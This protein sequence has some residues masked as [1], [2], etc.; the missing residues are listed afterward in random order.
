LCVCHFQELMDEPQVKISKHLNY[1]KRHG[2]VNARREANWMIYSLPANPSRELQAH[3]ACLQD[4]Q[5]EE[6]V[7]RKDAA[8]LA[9]LRGRFVSSSPICC[10]PKAQRSKL[11]TENV[12]S[13]RGRRRSG[14]S[15]RPR[16]GRGTHKTLQK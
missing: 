7:L 12:S 11:Q 6:P 14:A 8:R 9:S 15:N 3:L 5:R 10:G 2:L 4:C 13:V 16:R 1:L